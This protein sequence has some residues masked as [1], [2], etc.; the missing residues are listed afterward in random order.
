MSTADWIDTSMQGVAWLRTAKEAHRDRPPLAE[1]I[2]VDL[3]IV[4]GG[5][6]GLNAA[7]AAARAGLSVAVLEGGI[8]G[9]GASGRSGG[10]AVPNHPHGLTPAQAEAHLG[11]KKGAAFNALVLEGPDL[12]ARTVERYGI[13]SDYQQRGWIL[14]AH[15]EKSLK[16]VK[17]AH[18]QWTALGAQLDWLDAGEVRAATGAAGYLGGWR[19]ASGGTVNPFGQSQGLARAAEEEGARIHESSRVVNVAQKAAGEVLLEVRVPGGSHTVRAAKVLIATNAYTDDV[20][21]GLSRS[22]IPVYLYTCATHPLP[23]ELR[24]AIVPGCSCFTDLRDATGFARLDPA[25][26]LIAGGA[27]FASSTDPRGYGLRHSRETVLRLFP[28]LAA[29]GP[30]FQDY[31]EGHVCITEP[32]IPHVQRIDRDVFSLLGCS[33]RGVALMQALG[34]MM[35]EVFGGTRE[36]GE[37]PVEIVEG[38]RTIRLHGVK[39]RAGRNIFPLYRMKDRLGLT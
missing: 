11:P 4:G 31:W 37:V 30:D 21:P 13:R 10:Y 28:H 1:D 18:D 12:L 7:I 6:T 2:D 20:T 22:V 8:T 34:R 23:E 39:T 33:T 16:K 29:I 17:T 35:G 5:F 32:Y 9:V 19:N 26:R 15:S 36:L 27:V 25:G 24:A 38:T 3:A 14:P